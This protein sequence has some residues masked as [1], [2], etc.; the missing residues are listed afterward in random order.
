[1]NFG[2]I[3]LKRKTEFGIELYRIE[4][5]SENMA[6]MNIKG[7]FEGINGLGEKKEYIELYIKT[8][9][10]ISIIDPKDLEKWLKT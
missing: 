9:D 3:Y 5:N 4:L 1:M 10:P 6:E 7:V 2:E 8:Y